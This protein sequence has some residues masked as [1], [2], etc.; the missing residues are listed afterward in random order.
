VFKLLGIVGY[1]LGVSEA[2]LFGYMM[3][4]SVSVIALL[5]VLAIVFFLVT[6]KIKEWL[7]HDAGLV[8]YQQ[9]IVLIG[10]IWFVLYILDL[11]VYA[12]LDAV[13]LGLGSCLAAGRIGCAMAGCCHGRPA[14]W[15]IYYRPTGVYSGI[16]LAYKGVPVFPV[17]LIESFGVL[18]ILGIAVVLRLKSESDG[19]LFFCFS[20]A[21]NGLRFVLEFRRGDVDRLF[22]TGL[23]RAQWTAIGLSWLLLIPILELAEWLV[24]SH[25]II[26]LLIS[27]WGCAVLGA[28]VNDQIAQTLILPDHLVEVVEIARYHQINQVH[29]TSKGLHLSVYKASTAP[30]GV[31]VTL[32]GIT[33]KSPRRVMDKLARTVFSSY[34]IR[35]NRLDVR[36][37]RKQIYQYSTLFDS[38]PKYL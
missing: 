20:G 1:I 21:Y 2:S 23:S 3:G 18:V 17:Q 34:G 8:Y 35:W 10:G 30:Y 26:T 5:A 14:R 33:G 4:L 31:T 13:A 25:L 36:H 22:F 11:P 7:W 15:G 38:K 37:P 16:P 27:I 29:R 32:S 6:T 19:V 12:Y 24:V 9:H 28:A